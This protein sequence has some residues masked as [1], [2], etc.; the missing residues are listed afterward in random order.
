ML[1]LIHLVF[2]PSFG[3]LKWG[4]QGQEMVVEVVGSCTHAHTERCRKEETRKKE[5]RAVTTQNSP[6]HPDQAT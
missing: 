4:E 3:C 6:A 2:A 5:G 1:R